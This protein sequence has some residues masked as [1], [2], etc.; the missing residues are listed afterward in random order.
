M[1]K[2]LA[3]FLALVLA[4]LFPAAARADG[5]EITP[6]GG[7][8]AGGSFHLLD[9]L[10]GARAE[11][12]GG[13]TYGVGVGFRL[14]PGY[15]LKLIYGR[16]ESALVAKSSL[17]GEREKLLDVTVSHFHGGLEWEFGEDDVIRP[18]IEGVIGASLFAP[19]RDDLSSEWFFSGGVGGGVKLFF[20]R[21]VGLTL[22]ARYIPIVVRSSED[23]FCALPGGCLATFDQEYLSR[24]EAS[25]GLTFRF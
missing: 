2:T 15:L 18:F 21:H 16:Q 8:E 10:G 3:L 4:L 17:F 25:A 9:D 19:D 24:G 14:G 7:Y 6:Y 23:L 1:S 5:V 13:A 12:D 20:S 22:K 11:V